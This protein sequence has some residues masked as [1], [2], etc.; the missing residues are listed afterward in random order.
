M[1]EIIKEGMK[2]IEEV[3]AELLKRP[4]RRIVMD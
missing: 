3:M 2:E 4:R 1:K